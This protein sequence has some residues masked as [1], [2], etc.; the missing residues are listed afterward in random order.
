MSNPLPWLPPRH[1]ECRTRGLRYHSCPITQGRLCS[2][3]GGPVG[4]CGQGFRRWTV[5]VGGHRRRLCR[6]RGAR[7]GVQQEGGSG[8]WM[9]P[10]LWR[11]MGTK[12]RQERGRPCVWSCL[13]AV[14]VDVHLMASIACWQAFRLMSCH[15]V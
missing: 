1:E 10:G 15:V 8:W 12:H 3:R 5:H 13:T 14:F 7:Q 9:A 4:C 2:C 11:W 6:D